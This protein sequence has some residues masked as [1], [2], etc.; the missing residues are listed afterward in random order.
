MH[1]IAPIDTEILDEVKDYKLVVTAEEHLLHGGLGS[2]VA[3]YYC[4]KKDRPVQLMLGI[5]NQYPV[6]GRT[7]YIE[8]SYGLR[9]EQ[10]S[11]HILEK[12]EV[13]K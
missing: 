3:E 6:P 4:G 2:A 5:D 1:T 12:L 11:Q 10:I 8:Y 13:I 9:P 7:Q